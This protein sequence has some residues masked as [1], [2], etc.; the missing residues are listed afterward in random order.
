MIAASQSRPESRASEQAPRWRVWTLRL[1]LVLILL[2]GAFAVLGFFWLRSDLRERM[3]PPAPD[4]EP[5]E[6]S[7][8]AEK[9]SGNGAAP[10][11][12]HTLGTLDEAT[13]L[14]PPASVRPWTR[15]WW[16]GADVDPAQACKQ[17]RKLKAQGF[18]GV[19]IQP[20][21]ADLANV[22][23]AV[24]RDRIR[25]T[26][27]PEYLRTLRSVLDCAGDADMQVDLTHLSGWPAGGPQVSASEGL[28]EL[29]FS[30]LQ[31]DGGGPVDV[32]IPLPSPGFND[33]VLAFG[34]RE[35]GEDLSNFL[36]ELAQLKAVVAAPILAGERAFN[37]LD[38]TDTITLDPAKLVDLSTKVADGK[39]SWA[40]PEGRWQVVFVFV[41]PSGEAPTLTATRTPG[42]VIDHADA[43]TLSA[44]Y[45]WA[46]G[47]RSGL[48][49]FYGKSLRGIFNDS[50]E[51]KVDQ[52]AA[53][54]ILAEFA[55]RRSYDLTP[56]LPAVFQDFHDNYFIR[57]VGRRTAAPAFA[58]TQDDA[59]I[60][61]DYA[62]TM[63]DLM[64]E[65]F[66]EASK[67]WA[68]ARGM[69]SRG[70]SYGTDVDTIRALGA[71]DIPET[72]QLYGGGSP[73]FLKLA[74][75][76]GLLYDRPVV[77]A[78]SFVWALRANA[79]TPAQ[80][81]AAADKAYLA[82]INA[83]VWHGIPYEYTHGRDGER[84]SRDFGP[85]GWYPFTDENGGFIFSGNYGSASSIWSAEPELTEYMG[86]VQNLLQ[87]G[88]PQADVLVYYP[89]LGFPLEI[90]D[91]EEAREDFLFAGAMTPADLFDPSEPLAL[92]FAKFP[93]KTT[94]P[95]LEWIE[96][97]LPALRELDRAGVTW[98][99]VNDH[100][101]QSAPALDGDTPVIV[102][103]APYMQVETARALAKDAEG[104]RK[105]IV[106]GQPP[107]SQ[108]GYRDFVRN[109]RIVSDMM[110]AVAKSAAATSPQDL[111]Q[112]IAP[113]VGLSS[114]GDVRRISRDLGRGRTAHFLVNQSTTPQ[115][116]RLR[117][118]DATG[119]TLTAFDPL[120]GRI[121]TVTADGNG[122]VAL[123]LGR[124]ESLFVIRGAV[125]APNGSACG[126][127]LEGLT[128]RKL[129][130]WRIK[131]GTVS[132]QVDGPLRDLRKS[133]ALAASAGPVRYSAKVMVPAGAA[134]LCAVL[135]LQRIEGAARV[136]IN[137]KQ[138]TGAVLPPFQVD[139]TGKLRR[140]SN[141]IEIV[142]E[143][144]LRNSM[145][146]RQEADGLIE[147]AAAL[148]V[149]GG[150]IGQPRLL[151]GAR[152]GPERR[153]SET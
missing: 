149:P 42:F 50:L 70:Q 16:P 5:A 89:F 147:D 88:K 36:P 120:S 146:A 46:F 13:L 19:E 94:D 35:F 136:S 23:D 103:D 20:F 96:K 58:L 6:L 151:M 131:S 47:L 105:V 129:D 107:E 134:K 150:I 79:V 83:L 64:R 40:A 72:E 101:L 26:Q 144:P 132:M 7:S 63:S 104:G 153:K 39:L 123:E 148:F 76:A 25:D 18:A 38:V 29:A 12:T 24:W 121:W 116:A 74:G 112:R 138:A 127:S 43:A 51:F 80:I 93:D 141:I 114:N 143:P 14:E 75:A 49:P 109:D 86:R 56:F 87:A 145:A 137:G 113:A 31:L 10:D 124:L 82:G 28:K 140:G 118:R 2:A 48:G 71:N 108:P 15:W 142:L 17:L 44:H 54:D 69:L 91:S 57:E 92:P 139:L 90:E 66:V 22:E 85:A 3:V 34:E 77:S 11:L 115:V 37:V 53:S 130:R 52:L 41:M 98:T 55:K 99:W 133:E 100:A 125:L 81:K 97:V 30:E 84:L 65:R 126:P 9:F 32:E 59:R 33:Y 4:Q 68:N 21:T 8:F 60:R 62:L 73:L 128:A 135:D 45:D 111:L 106:Y 27:S 122:V 95:R 110:R 152:D 78:E 61:Y 67:T 1:V 102:A 119:E 117:L